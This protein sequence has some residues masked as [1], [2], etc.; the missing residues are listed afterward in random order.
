MGEEY[1]N[2]TIILDKDF[3]DFEW[4]RNANTKAIY[5]HFLLNASVKERRYEGKLLPKYS[6]VSSVSKIAEACGISIKAVK[7]A[8]EHLE[9]S[10]H[11]RKKSGN[12]YTIF[13][14]NS[15]EDY[16]LCK[17]EVID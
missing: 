16:V 11:I 7:I 17:E 5:I 10:G 1:M 12:K 2:N 13:T 14:V 4:Y 3:V 8:I 15:Y 9:K 6:F